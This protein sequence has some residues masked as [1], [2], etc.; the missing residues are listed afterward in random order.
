MKK[1]QRPIT[2]LFMLVSVDGKI[3]TW[4]T[5]NLDFDKDLPKVEWIKEGL[6]QYY[7][8]E[9]TTDLYSLNSWK[10]QAKIWMNIPQKNIVKTDVNFIIIDDKPYLNEIGIDNFIKKSN[11]LFIVTTNKLHPA[12]KKED[13]ENI[14]IIY[15]ENNIDFDDLFNKFKTKYNIDSITIQAWWTLNS[16]LLRKKLIDKIHIIIAPILIWGKNTSTLIDWASFEHFED[17]LDLKA[18]QLREVKNLDN[19]YLELKYDVINETI[20]S[21]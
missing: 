7:D 20:I 1:I 11:K 21:D 12:F 13:E 14:E 16:I 9:K 4:S 8:I 5:D 19:S 18:L 3:S 10:V 2:T 6:N 15:Y 17:L